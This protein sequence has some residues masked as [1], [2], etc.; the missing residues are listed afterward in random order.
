MS[1]F[2]VRFGK[3]VALSAL[4]LAA[5]GCES[6]R[7]SMGLRSAETD[8]AVD[9]ADRPGGEPAPGIDTPLDVKSEKPAP[10]F[11]NSRLSGGLSDQAREIERDLGIR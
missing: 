4:T 10:F 11:K 1:R 3:L 2:L 5:A 6:M 8:A 7:Q 9:L